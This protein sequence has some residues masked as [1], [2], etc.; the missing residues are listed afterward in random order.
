MPVETEFG[1]T[2]TRTRPRRRSLG[3]VAALGVAA[4]LFLAG[5]GDVDPDEFKDLIDAAQ[6]AAEG[7]GSGD[8]PDPDFERRMDRARDWG[9]YPEPP[10][11]S[12]GAVSGQ[13]VGPNYRGEVS[14]QEDIVYPGGQRDAIEEYYTREYGTSP[15]RADDGELR[16]RNESSR[17]SMADKPNGK[18]EVSS[19]WKKP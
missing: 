19:S 16:W 6:S 10:P 3:G 8:G 11:I 18:V 14:A 2:R 4:P 1:G 7:D 5:C 12:S 9:T 13:G 15:T 17:T